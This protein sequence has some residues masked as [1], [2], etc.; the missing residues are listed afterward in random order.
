MFYD[1]TFRAPCV[2]YKHPH[3]GLLTASF[4]VKQAATHPSYGRLV[5]FV[6]LLR[7]GFTKEK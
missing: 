1:Q 6:V 7:L 2:F 4:E 5:K 3:R